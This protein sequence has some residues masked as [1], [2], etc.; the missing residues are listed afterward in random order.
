MSSPNSS[1]KAFIRQQIEARAKAIK[2]WP[3]P[4]HVISYMTDD[5]EQKLADAVAK[6]VTP[7]YIR[8]AFS[9]SEPSPETPPA[10]KS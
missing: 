8:T 6:A 5:V 9:K 1:S 3:L 10:P 2:F 7:A 4:A